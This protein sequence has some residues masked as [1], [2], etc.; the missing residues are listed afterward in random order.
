MMCYF[1]KKKVAF[2]F[3]HLQFFLD[4]MHVEWHGGDDIQKLKQVCYYFYATETY[5]L[6]FLED[7]RFPNADFQVDRIPPLTVFGHNSAVLRA[8]KCLG[9][10]ATTKFS[11]A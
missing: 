7:A 6:H 11:F 2:S 8:V 9:P 10:E 4:N 1:F 5:F 3:F